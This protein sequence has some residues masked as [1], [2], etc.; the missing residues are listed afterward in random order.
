MATTSA[1]VPKTLDGNVKQLLIGGEGRDAIGGGTISV[2][3]PGTG[4]PFVTAADGGSAD[5]DAAVSSARAALDGPWAKWKPYDRQRALIKLAE[6]VEADFDE[7][8]LLD[9]MSMGAPWAR[10]RISRR[11]VSLLHWYASQAVNMRG[12]TIPNSVVGDF[13]SYTVREP[14]GVVGGIIP[15]NGPIPAAIWKLGPVLATGC[16]IVLKPAP[17]APLSALR[18][19]QLCLEAGIP[20]GVVN[21]VPGGAAAGAALAAHPGVDKIAFTGSQT[22]GQ[23]IVRA[24]AGN[25]KRLTLELGGKS[26]DIVF[27]D[28]DLDKAVPGAAMAIFGNSGQVCSAGSRLFVQREIYDEFLERLVTFT[29]QLVVGDALDPT[30]QLGPLVSSRQ[31]DRVLEYVESGRNDGARAVSGGQRLTDGDLANG[32][33]LAPTIFDGV[34]DDM[35]IARE[36]IFGPVV[37]ALPF[38]DEAEAIRRANDTDFGLGAGIWTRDVSRVQRMANAVKAGSVWVNGYQAMDPAVPFGGYKL[39]GYGSESG[40][41]QLD[42]YLKVKSVWIN[43]E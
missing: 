9:S 5:I 21:V 38:D 36:E 34:R 24:S 4:Q 30:T 20:P 10:T 16:T 8:S 27:A 2:V 23:E 15:W 28:A 13:F 17:E 35:R 43:Q 1:P 18:L 42:A 14:V 12:E 19:G 26:P 41:Q 29:S 3:N 22:A 39:S 40:I 33:F 37:V 32:Y 11:P 7:M 6:L 25:L 31:L